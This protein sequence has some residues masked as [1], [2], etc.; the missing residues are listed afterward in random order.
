MT[1]FSHEKNINTVFKNPQKRSGL[2]AVG[3]T[4]AVLERFLGLPA[5]NHCII[6]SNKSELCSKGNANAQN[7]AGLEK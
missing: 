1:T 3:Y 6:A 5:V 2:N 4:P 7:V